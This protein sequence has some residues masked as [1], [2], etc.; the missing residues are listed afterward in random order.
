M[1]AI[2]A[3]RMSRRADAPPAAAVDTDELAR[4]DTILAPRFYT[5]DFAK[6]DRTDVSSVRGEWDALIAELKS[7]PNRT[8]FKRTEEWD[9]IDLAALPDGLRKEFVDFLVSSLTAEFSGCILYKEMKRRGKNA[10]I[11][12]LFT[13]MSRDEA[14]H[15]GF[16]N[17]ALK[18]FGIG[19]NLSFL[20][21]TKKY[22]F[23]QPKFIFYATYLSEKIGYARYITIFRHLEQHPER[24]FHPIFKWF[25]EVV[26]RRVPPRRS[27]RDPDAIGSEAAI[28]GQP[29]VDP[30][31]P[32]RRLRH[33]VCARPPAAGLPCR[34]RHRSHRLRLTASSTSPRRSPGRS[35]RWCSTQTTPASAP[36][37]SASACDLRPH[38]RGAPP[39]RCQGDRQAATPASPPMRRPSCGSTR[40]RRKRMPGPRR[41]TSNRCGDAR[42]S[43]S[44]QRPRDLL[45][46]RL[47]ARRSLV[48][49]G[50]RRA[51][52]RRPARLHDPSEERRR[53]DPG[54]PLRPRRADDRRSRRSR[55][56]DRSRDGRQRRRSRATLERLLVRS[57]PSPRPRHGW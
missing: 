33:D 12:E 53:S 43:R 19:V 44:R 39:G 38:R 7:D 1:S 45:G 3:D 40:C 35:S 25:R 56:P 57:D 50:S 2:A 47:S 26:Q 31:L 5:T 10:D 36:A 55:G 51:A 42:V 23:F 34:A 11:K 13:Y 28:R 32:A 8:H 9:R 27:L 54:A 30:L 18:E 52:C 14:R 16:I 46:A 29:P 17:D 22:T 41:A 15:A 48:G 37:S 4:E 6:L 24:R 49:C 21:K 20:T